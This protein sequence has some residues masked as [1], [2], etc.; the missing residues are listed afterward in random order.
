MSSL[1]EIKTWV[2]IHVQFSRQL[3]VFTIISIACEGTIRTEMEPRWLLGKLGP[4]EMLCVPSLG[5]VPQ[6]ELSGI[7]WCWEGRGFLMGKPHMWTPFWRYTGTQK[8]ACWVQ[9][10][11][12]WFELIPGQFKP[13]AV[14]RFLFTTRDGAVAEDWFSEGMY[15]VS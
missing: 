8:T 3:L 14:L 7:V 1:V 12:H 5:L 15:V 2:G 11:S 4:F 10:V 9:T 6:W 13:I